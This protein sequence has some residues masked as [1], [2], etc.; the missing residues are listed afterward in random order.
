[1]ASLRWIISSS[2]AKYALPKTGGA[3]KTSAA[4]IKLVTVDEA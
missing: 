3:I 4:M 2:E 1:M